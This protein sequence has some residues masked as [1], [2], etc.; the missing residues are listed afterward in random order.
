MI[1]TKQA[2]IE[3]KLAATFSEQGEFSELSLSFQQY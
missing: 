1:N 3:L 2:E